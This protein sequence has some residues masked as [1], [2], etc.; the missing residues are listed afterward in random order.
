MPILNIL[1]IAHPVL[2]FR[3]YCL[4]ISD[5]TPN[6]IVPWLNASHLIA[7]ID[8]AEGPCREVPPPTWLLSCLLCANEGFPKWKVQLLWGAMFLSITEQLMCKQA[9]IQANDGH[10]T[11]RQDSG[12]VLQWALEVSLAG[13]GGHTVVASRSSLRA[14]C[15]VS[16]SYQWYSKV[17]RAEM[18]KKRKL[19]WAS[20]SV[21]VA[22]SW[23]LGCVDQVWGA[24]GVVLEE[25]SDC[26]PTVLGR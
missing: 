16:C 21:W 13:E 6:N 22:S 8:T 3:E 25:R 18:L 26:S 20:P 17:L 7:C 11:I 9:I 10:W 12:S 1:N 2:H 5:F 14:L 15:T 23:G 24:W 19:Q 4:I